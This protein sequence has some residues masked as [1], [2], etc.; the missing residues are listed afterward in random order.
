MI[1]LLR[2]FYVSLLLLVFWVSF[3]CISIAILA[4]YVYMYL[5]IECV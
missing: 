3:F 4:K 5:F 2:L 1:S